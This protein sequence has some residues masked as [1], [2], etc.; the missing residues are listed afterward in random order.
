MGIGHERAGGRGHRGALLTTGFAVGP[1]V[2]GLV[3]SAGQSGLWQSFVIAAVL[4]ILATIAAV[5]AAYR[6]PVVTVATRPRVEPVAERR[7]SARH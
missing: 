1:F 3:A 4:I 5:V 6:S 7:G 2:A